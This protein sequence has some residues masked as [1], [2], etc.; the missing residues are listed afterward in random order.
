MPPFACH[1]RPQA[2]S[3]SDEEAI[4]RREAAVLKTSLGRADVSART[5][6][7]LLV[8]AIY[9]EML[10]FEA[11]FAYIHAVNITQVCAPDWIEPWAFPPP[12]GG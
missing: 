9:C 10:G 3:K 8:R 6:K 2:K 12:R 11:E 4:V 5:R 1:P 7:E